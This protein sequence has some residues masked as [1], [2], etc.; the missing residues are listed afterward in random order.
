VRF[1]ARAWPDPAEVDDLCHETY[2]R[3][4]EAATHAFP[5]SPR[6]FLFATARHLMADR[7]RR[8]RVVS[9][10]LQEDLD[11]LNVLIDEASPERL[12]GVR[13]DL[14]HLARAFESLPPKCRDVMWLLKVEELPQKE[15]AQRLNLTVKAVEKRVTNGYYLLED[16]Y[17][18]Q[19]KT[20]DAAKKMIDSKEWDHG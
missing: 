11:A 14:W 17:R 10:E 8:G 12:V 2:I 3:V 13:Q 5:T 9:I 4:Y 20:R 19:L 6:G 1:L 18:R 7:V 15:I 16:A